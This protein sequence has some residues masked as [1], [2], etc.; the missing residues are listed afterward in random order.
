MQALLTP[1]GPDW[2]AI[3]M[4]SVR[5]VVAAPGLAVVPTAPAQVL[6]LFNLRGEIVPLFDTSALLGLGGGTTTEFAV[7]VFTPAGPAGRAATG[8]PEAV[9]LAE[10]IGGAEIAG[11]VGSYAV[12]GRVATLLDV[13]VLLAPAHTGGLVQ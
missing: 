13:D 5:E 10:P 2:Y 7:V 8:A 9:E 4:A 12:G 6:G 3:G 1:V 11:G